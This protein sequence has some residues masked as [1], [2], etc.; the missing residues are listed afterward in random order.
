MKL[1]EQILDLYI[2]EDVIKQT[3]YELYYYCFD[4]LFSELLYDILILGIAFI[5]GQVNVT[6]AYYIGFSVIR[7]TSGGYHAESPEKCFLLSIV[8]YFCSLGLIHIVPVSIYPEILISTL[9]LAF[10][11]IWWFAPVDHPNKRFSAREK[12]SYRRK[13]QVAIIISIVI[14]IV[15]LNSYSLISWAIT[16]GVV[17]AAISVA[18]AQMKGRKRIC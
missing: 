6:I 1:V 10:F 4:T 15:L 12:L 8:V 17:T 3:E 16:V 9:L 5:L 2:A 13:S 14:A 7:Y 18:I 11:L